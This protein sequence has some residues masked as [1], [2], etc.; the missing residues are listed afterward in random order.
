M[1]VIDGFREWVN[2]NAAVASIGAAA[3]CGIALVVMVTQGAGNSRDINIE[4]PAYYYD[5]TT[6]KIFTDSMDKIPPITSPDGNEAVRV[7]LFSCGECTEEERFVGYY[8]KYTDEAR[9]T[10]TQPMEASSGD[11]GDPEGARRR[12]MEQGHRISQDGETWTQGSFGPQLRNEFAAKCNSPDM[13]R[14]CKP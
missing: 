11:S 12:A 1:G 2:K 14:S 8:E 4:R 3:L 5:L 13:L 6:E 9:K 7:H 10:L